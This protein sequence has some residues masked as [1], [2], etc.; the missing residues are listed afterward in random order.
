MQHGPLLQRAMARDSTR[1]HLSRSTLVHSPMSCCLFSR[2]LKPRMHLLLLPTQLRNIFQ[3]F[4]RM[5]SLNCLFQKEGYVRD[6][7]FERCA[8][9]IQAIWTI[10][11]G[12]KTASS[13]RCLPLPPIL[14]TH[15][16]LYPSSFNLCSF[17][18]QPASDM[19][20]ITNFINEII[21]AHTVKM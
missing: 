5:D 18:L 6:F 8:I 3:V 14:G 7:E 19:L 2:N 15:F 16:Y 20:I 10:L 17:I 21:A 13:L 1:C 12:R 11:S 9:K 4:I